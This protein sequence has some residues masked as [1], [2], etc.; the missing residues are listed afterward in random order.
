MD[1]RDARLKLRYMFTDDS[2]AEQRGVRLGFADQDEPVGHLLCTKHASDTLDRKLSGNNRKKAR[3]H[4][5]TAMFVRKTKAGCRESVTAAIE[6]LSSQEDKQYLRKEWLSNID[7][8]ALCARSHSCILLQ[9][10]N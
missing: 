8:W 6:S 1:W 5:F 4:M 3:D 9:L 7:S 10:S 2:A